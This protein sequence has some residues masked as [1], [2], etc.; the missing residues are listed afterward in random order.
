MTSTEFTEADIHEAFRSGAVYRA[1]NGITYISKGSLIES[2]R[3]AA[4]KKAACRLSVIFD[5]QAH[6]TF[7]VVMC[8]EHGEVGRNP[9]GPNA[10]YIAN[11]HLG[12]G[13]RVTGQ[14]SWLVQAEYATQR[15]D[16]QFSIADIEAAWR[17]LGW[18]A[19]DRRALLAA[20]AGLVRQ[21][22]NE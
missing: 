7:W 21:E 9:D 11:Q 14:L 13:Q 5:T 8:S 3:N 18:S 19:S 15:E 20:L 10:E 4:A 17:V 12:N 1:D 2:L 22:T 16:A 6:V